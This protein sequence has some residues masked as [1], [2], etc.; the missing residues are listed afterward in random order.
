[1]G[2]LL[3]A[4][5][6]WLIPFRYG[7]ERWSYTLQRI[8]GVVVTLYFVAHV[9]ETGFVVGG[10]SVWSVRPDSLQYAEQVWTNTIEFLANPLFDAG[11]VIIG[12]MVAFHT[13]NG[14]RLFLTHMGWSLGKP[15]RP[16]FPYR[17]ASMTLLQ[18]IL[19]WVSIAFAVF[20]ILYTIDAFFGVLSHG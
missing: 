7:L 4:L 9:A 18:R 1:M 15:G 19:F 17:P 20:A 5:K 8:T 16:E 14:I 10:P 3:L 13:I 11:L 12:G 6:T 2:S